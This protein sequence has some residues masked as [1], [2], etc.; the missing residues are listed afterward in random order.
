MGPIWGRQDPGGPHVGPM[1][2]AIWVLAWL[3]R[4]SPTSTTECLNHSHSVITQY[5]II[6]IAHDLF[7]PK[8]TSWGLKGPVAYKSYHCVSLKNRFLLK[9][10]VF[11]KNIVLHNIMCETNWIVKT[12]KFYR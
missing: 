4:D 3:S 11:L 12:T 10:Y 1:N 8:E 7:N 9:C 6:E 5:G 2:F